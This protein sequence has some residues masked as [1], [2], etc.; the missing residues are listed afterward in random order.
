MLIDDQDKFNDNMEN[1]NDIEE[2]NK[3]DKQLT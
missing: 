1:L 3:K 2:Q